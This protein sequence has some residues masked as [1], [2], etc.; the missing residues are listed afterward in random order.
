MY[1]KVSSL[2]ASVI[3]IPTF[4]LFWKCINFP[5]GDVYELFGPFLGHNGG[6]RR[7]VVDPYDVSNALLL[8]LTRIGIA[9]FRTRLMNEIIFGS[10]PLPVFI[11]K[12]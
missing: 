11:G 1:H 10:P 12:L 5:L 4:H 7:V 8:A 9:T 2:P 3:L 6:L